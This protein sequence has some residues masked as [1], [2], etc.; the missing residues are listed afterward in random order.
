MHDRS[1]ESSRILGRLHQKEFDDTCFWTG[2]IQLCDKVIFVRVVASLQWKVVIWTGQKKRIF[3]RFWFGRLLAFSFSLSVVCF[4]TDA[5]CPGGE[6]VCI[7]FIYLCHCMAKANSFQEK[8]EEEYKNWTEK[9]SK[10]RASEKKRTFPKVCHRF[11]FA[12][13]HV[14]LFWFSLSIHLQLV[15]FIAHQTNERTKN[16]ADSFL[17]WWWSCVYLSLLS[18]LIECQYTDSDAHS[19]KQWVQGAHRTHQHQHRFNSIDYVLPIENRQSRKLRKTHTQRENEWVRDEPT[20]NAKQQSKKW[21]WEIE[22][23]S[24]CWCFAHSISL[25]N[26]FRFV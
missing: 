3:I 21:I 23:L 1:E 8:R 26:Y 18:P 17:L 2:Q 5:F 15:F 19:Q 7:M 4:Y 22:T 12:L 10:N 20:A 6:C 14:Y 24:S 13:W 11:L 25:A 9:K 16:R